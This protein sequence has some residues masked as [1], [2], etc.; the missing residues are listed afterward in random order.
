V[1]AKAKVEAG[2]L[3]AERW[4]IARLRHRRFYSIGEANV[5]IADCVAAI[6]VRPFKKMDG[7]RK[8]LFELLDRPALRPLPPQRYEFATFRHAKVSIDYH[9]E[10]DHH[11]Y[12][13]PYQLIGKVVDVRSSAS[14]IEVFYSSKRVASHLRSFKRGQFTTDPAHMPESHRRYAQW[15]PSRIIAWAARTGPST[16]KLVESILASRPHPEQGFRSAL[17]IIRLARRC[18]RRSCWSEVRTVTK[19]ATI[20]LHGN[21][22]EVDAALVG[23]RVEVVFDPFDLETVEIRFKG[24]SMGSG[25]P[26]SIGRHAHPSARPEAAPRP[27]PTGIDYLGLLAQRREAELAQSIIN[28]SQLS[29]QSQELSPAEDNDNDDKEI[30]L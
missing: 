4:I 27:A 11:Y 25:V 16:A 30:Q 6:N 2:V 21:A 15:T 13:V 29:L 8:I 3:L 1:D 26:V 5:A 18:M 12:S 9:V 7:S 23:S 24:R 20:S 17:G 19:T 14:T 22:F 10:A 28:Y